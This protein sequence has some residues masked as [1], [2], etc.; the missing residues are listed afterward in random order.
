[1]G[2]SAL[3]FVRFL[4][5]ISMVLAASIVTVE[6]RVLIDRRERFESHTAVFRRNAPV[7]LFSF[8]DGGCMFELLLVVYLTA[9]LHIP[10]DTSRCN[11]R[12]ADKWST[13]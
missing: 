1:M 2:S 12:I 8:E 10:G 13:F 9:W 6:K 11:H 3:W 7:L 4:P 5:G